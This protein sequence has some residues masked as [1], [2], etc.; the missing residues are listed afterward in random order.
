ME[1]SPAAVVAEHA[2]RG[3]LA[4]QL[5]ADGRPQW[6]PRLGPFSWAVSAGRGVV[7]ATTTVRRRGEDAADVS[8]VDLDEGFR[9]MSRVL[10]GPHPIGTRVRVVWD[11]DLPLFEAER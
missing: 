10:G 5:D 7:Y 2:A 6:P 1:S 4:Y 8:L 9:M 11:G 3:E